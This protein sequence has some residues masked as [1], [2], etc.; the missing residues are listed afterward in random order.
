M[1]FVEKLVAGKISKQ[2]YVDTDAVF[3]KKKSELLSKITGIMYIL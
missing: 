3:S 2:Q 1:V